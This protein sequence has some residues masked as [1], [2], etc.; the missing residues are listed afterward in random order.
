MHMADEDQGGWPWPSSAPPRPDDL[1]VLY[2]L[3][4]RL[5]RA[6]GLE[7]VYQAALDAIR[8]A[9]GCSRSS[10]LL[11]DHAGVMRFVAWRGLSD[12]Y[13]AAVDGHSPWRLGQPSP[14]PVLVED[15]A[16]TSEPAEVKE[17]IAAEGI[18]GLAFVPL[19]VR[20]GTIGKFMTYYEER[21]QFTQREVDLAV[22]IARQVGFSIERAQADEERRK[23]EEAL[24]KQEQRARA[25]LENAPVMI[26][27]SDANGRC[28]HLNRKLREFWAVPDR[29]IGLFDWSATIHPDDAKGVVDAMAR[30]I[31]ERTGVAMQARYRAAQGGYRVLVTDA[32]PRFSPAGEF[33][34]MIGVNVDVTEREEAESLRQLLVAELNHRVK[35]TLAVV[36]GIAQQTFKGAAA[37]PELQAAFLGR[38]NALALAHGMLTE[39][40]WRHA[41]LPDIVADTLRTAAVSLSRLSLSGPP[42]LLEPK[43]ALA[44]AMALHELVTNAVKYGAFS[45]DAGRVSVTWAAAHEASSRFRLEW[46]E[47]GGPPVAPPRR[48]GFGSKLIERLAAQDLG[49][50]ASHEFRAEGIRCVLEG[51]AA[52]GACGAPPNG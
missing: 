42:I 52:D 43:A 23:A 15:I 25:M 12:P 19:V 13:R 34:G 21:H 38:L 39:S 29:D 5:F 28:E 30:A 20:G 6:L 9:L 41:S 8:A 3:T 50:A 45:N 33:L 36:Q 49:G 2:Q 1:A 14:D 7:E 31:Q 18:V 16:L 46:V 4:D 48:V 37:P 22:M 51:R 32:Q 44:A 40:S 47:T 17:A 26:W 27:T 10:I 11:F 35:N 24:R